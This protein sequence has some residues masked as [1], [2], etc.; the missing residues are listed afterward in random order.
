MKTFN[1]IHEAYLGILRDVYTKPE[2][3][4]APRGQGIKEILDYQF[5]ITN[6][7]AEPIVTK[8]PERNKTIASYT[9]KEFDLYNSCS[10]RVDDFAK[11][12]SFWK[13]IANPDDTVNSAYGYLIWNKESCGNPEFEYE[14]T[15]SSALVPASQRV[16]IMRTPWQWAVECLKKDKDSRQAILRFSL[17]EHQ[18]LA[19]KD[20]TCTL[21]GIF[22]IREDKLHLSIVMRSNDVVLGLAYDLPWF[23]SLIERMTQDLKDSFPDIKVGSY[24]HLSHSM[25]LYD[26]DEQ[27]VRKMLGLD[28]EL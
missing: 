28:D 3:E 20:Q 6:P 13:K 27:R 2:H 17:P 8:D 22:F 15:P 21:H 9:K 16:P 7:V 23:I 10:N 12:S 1:D 24:T 11:A 19:N 4:C 26:R 25:H 18:W 5:R 14:E